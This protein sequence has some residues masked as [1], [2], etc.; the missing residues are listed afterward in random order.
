MAHLACDESQSANL[1]HCQPGSISAQPCAWGAVPGANGVRLILCRL[2][3]VVI[4]HRSVTAVR[5]SCAPQCCGHRTPP[6]GRVCAL[7]VR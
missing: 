5:R 1:A 3:A 6:G 4:K 2:I 7:V